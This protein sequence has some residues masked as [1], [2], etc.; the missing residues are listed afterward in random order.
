[1]F[2]NSTKKQLKNRTL[3][4]C[5][6]ALVFLLTGCGTVAKVDNNKIKNQRDTFINGKSISL[7]FKYR[8]HEWRDSGLHL[9]GQAPKPGETQEVDYDLTRELK[10]GVILQ[11]VEMGLGTREILA[12]FEPTL[13]Q[14]LQSAGAYVSGPKEDFLLNATLTFGPT[15]APAYADYNLG[16]SLGTSL[17]TMGLAPRQYRLRTDYTLNL[18]LRDANS[19]KTVK[20]KTCKSNQ[21]H[22]HSISKFDLSNTQQKH[23]DAAKDLFVDSL[24]GCLNDFLASF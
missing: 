20:E 16:K 23:I 24:E 13:T 2:S 21:E 6:F 19:G 7:K 5:S 22:A 15:P 1:M 12:R 11:D 8:Q 14:A 17:L 3:A 9:I 10:K 18:A 4:S